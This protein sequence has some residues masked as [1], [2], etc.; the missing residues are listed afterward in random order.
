LGIQIMKSPT[1]SL[2]TSP[3]MLPP[4]AP[5]I[6]NIH[7]GRSTLKHRSTSPHRISPQRST[8]RR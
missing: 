8:R 6:K 3:V 4:A 2:N 7:N 1:N 5:Y